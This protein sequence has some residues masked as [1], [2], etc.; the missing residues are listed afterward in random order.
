MIKIKIYSRKSDNAIF[1]EEEMEK[2]L[3]DYEE[4]AKDNEGIDEY[5][6]EHYT[7]S[8]LF[9]MDREEKKMIENEYNTY[10]A[11]N[12]GAM[13]SEDFE[14]IWLST[15]FYYDNESG[16]RVYVESNGDD[17]VKYH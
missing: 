12:V 4:I 15:D 3:S 9:H 16:E 6:D 5:L 1:T 14:E 8:E 11:D 13:V 2:V 7:P 10:I 17:L